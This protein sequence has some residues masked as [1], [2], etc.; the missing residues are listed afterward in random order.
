MI[1]NLIENIE[2]IFDKKNNTKTENYEI[3]KITNKFSNTKKPIYKLV[4]GGVEVS[5]NNDLIVKYKCVCCELSSSIT[6]NLFIRKLN[7][8]IVRCG[9]CKNKDEEKRENHREFYKSGEFKIKKEI[10]KPSLKSLIEESNKFWETQDEDF[11]DVYFRKHLTLEEFERIRDKIIS[12]NHDKIID[13]SKFEY[14]P[15]FKISNQSLFNPKLVIVNDNVVE[16]I[17]YIKFKCENC[18]NN[19]LRK[20]LFTEKNKYKILCSDCSFCNKT[21]KIRNMKNCDGVKVIYQ[22]QF[23]KKFITYCNENKIVILNGDIINYVWKNK[24]L[25]YKIDFKIPSKKLLVELKDEHKWYKDE[26]KN[27]KAE[28]KVEFAEKFAKNIGYKYELVFQNKYM[29]FIS[30]Y[31]NSS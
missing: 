1:K 25:K 10:T 23:E 21:F 13:I 24:T 5:R 11:R 31:F 18:D 20:D 9:L 12:I 2:S 27:G 30:S 3:Q 22:S 29:D 4:V 14:I 17:S 15:H 7:Q 19:F 8:N 28:C 26:V 6:L 16:N